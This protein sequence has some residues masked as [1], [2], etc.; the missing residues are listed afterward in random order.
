MGL[1]FFDEQYHDI[2]AEVKELVRRLKPSRSM[3]PL[4]DK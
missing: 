3:S 2:R 4:T 1:T